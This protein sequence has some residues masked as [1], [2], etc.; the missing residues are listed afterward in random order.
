[1]VK[2]AGAKFAPQTFMCTGCKNHQTLL[3]VIW[4]RAWNS[5]FQISSQAMLML[6]FS[7]HTL[8]NEWLRCSKRRRSNYTWWLTSEERFHTSPQCDRIG[9]K[10][11]DSMGLCQTETHRWARKE[12]CDHKIMQSTLGEQKR[13]GLVIS[14]PLRKYERSPETWTWLCPARWA[15]TPN[16]SNIRSKAQNMANTGYK[17]TASWYSRP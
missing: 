16:Q 15:D 13:V 2:G 9:Q 10:K 11:K 12:M 4:G 3:Q 1:M 6:L 7:N 17:E 8:R 5:L 14:L